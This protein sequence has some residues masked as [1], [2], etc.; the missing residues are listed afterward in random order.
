MAHRLSTHG[1]KAHRNTPVKTYCRV[2][3]TANITIATA[4]NSG[5]TIDGV[6]LATNDR[7]LV[8][9]Q[10]SGA[11]NGIYVVAAA[12]ARAEDM[13]NAAEV[14]GALVYVIAGTANAGKLYK[15][16]NT[17]AVTLDTTAL[18]FAEFSGGVTD[19]GALTGLADDDHS[20]YVL[21]YGGGEETVAPAHGS[22]GA[23]ETFN[24]AL[25]NW[26]TGTFDANCTFTFTGPTTGT[27]CSLLLELAQNGTGGWTVTL[28]ASFVNKAALEA[29]Q[30]TTAST[31]SF[32]LV[33]TRDGGTTWYGAWVGGSGSASF[34][35]PA[36]VLGT[37]AAAGAASTVIRSDSTIVAFDVTVPTTI[38]AGATA[39]TGAAAVAARRD[40]T[41]GAPA[42]FG[43]T[44][45]LM[46]TGIAPPD[47]LLDAEGL[48]WLVST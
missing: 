44:G 5:D 6:V 20:A 16:T 17:S 21:T 2:A 8:K 39:A 33:W 35:T 43:I 47:P 31:T 37:A 36:I 10:S 18:T 40:H 28:P 22:M 14:L 41:H 3:T 1:T 45:I 30:V 19:H 29:A 25:G 26:H 9:D 13:D 7:V 24:P 23:T 34:A 12:P 42:S 15:N 46:A 48:D 11:Q 32:L 4:L 38:A 27:G